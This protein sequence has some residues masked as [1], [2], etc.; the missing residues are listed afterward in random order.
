MNNACCGNCAVGAPCAGEVKGGA[1][2]VSSPRPLG[3]IARKMGIGQVSVA[4]VPAAPVVGAVAG[5]FGGYWAAGMVA[6]K[7]NG[8][9]RLIG[10]VLGVWAGWSAGQASGL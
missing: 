5:G 10:A 9:A 1:P 4:G 7:R 2:V 3:G 8:V 6:G